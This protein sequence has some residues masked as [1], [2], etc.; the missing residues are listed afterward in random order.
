MK[1]KTPNSLAKCEHYP[2]LFYDTESGTFV[3]YY[4]DR[5]GFEKWWNIYREYQEFEP[6]TVQVL[7]VNFKRKYF[8]MESIKG[9]NLEHEMIK[10][11][12]E[13]TKKVLIQTL[14][15]FSNQFNF[16]CNSMYETEVFY[17]KDFRTE[18]LMFD[19]NNTVRLVDPDSF[20]VVPLDRMNNLLF[21]GKYMDTLNS[22]RERLSFAELTEDQKYRL[23]RGYLY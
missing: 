13:D 22:I 21:F 20:S 18:N 5:Y 6:R 11:D 16:K 15:L 17:H 9:I 4:N 3:K 23:G 1:N 14:D 12:F 8:V 19:E 10:L 7:E 2:T